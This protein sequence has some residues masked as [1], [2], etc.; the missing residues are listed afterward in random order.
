MSR[1]YFFPKYSAKGPSSRYRIY[2]YLP[3][4]KKKGI[5]YK[6]YPLFGDW[7]LNALWNS[8][9]RVITAAKVFRAYGKRLVRILFLPSNALVYIGADL[10]PYVPPIME[11]YL[12]LRKIRYIVDY[13]DAIFH[14]YDQHKNRLIR[15]M[16]GAKINKVNQWA[17]VII[18]GSTYLTQEARRSNSHVLEIPTSIDWEKYG[19]VYPQTGK[20]EFIIGWIGSPSQSQQ[21]INI[22]DALKEL[23]SRIPFELHL[24]GFD[25]KEK[26]KLEG[27]PYKII[28]WKE[29][30]EIEEMQKFHVGIMPLED[31]PFNRG[32]C[33]FKLVQYMALGLPTVASPLPANININK[34]SNNLFA[35]TT[36][37][38]VDCLEYMYNNQDY[39]LTVGD[40]N[41]E[42]AAQYYT[43]QSNSKIYIELF[44]TFLH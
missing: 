30:T 29:N 7:Y 12:K 28:R 17:S 14:R 22:K 13:D 23:K 3:F 8:Q 2:N 37:E 32:K 11:Y 6:I 40:R 15:Y 21:V 31:T 1:I 44:K 16:L 25:E 10:F 39:F 38:W 19:P 5:K 24:I 27:I 35:A 43:I 33:A 41:K 9:S 36:E 20:N 42:I 26:D 34:N 4:Y 18:T